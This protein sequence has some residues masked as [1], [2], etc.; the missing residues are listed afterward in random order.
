M[1]NDDIYSTKIFLV[2]RANSNSLNSEI[3]KMTLPKQLG[4]IAPLMKPDSSIL[5]PKHFKQKRFTT[6][7]CAS[8]LLKKEMFTHGTMG[9]WG[10]GAYNIN[11]QEKSLQWQFLA[12]PENEFSKAVL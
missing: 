1:P 2:V 6:M 8:K 4:W 11:I 12:Y 7:T 5:K 10:K 3:I 9:A